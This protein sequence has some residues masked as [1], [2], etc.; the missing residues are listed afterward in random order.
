MSIVFFEL[1]YRWSVVLLNW[2]FVKTSPACLFWWKHHHPPSW[3]IQICLYSVGSCSGASWMTFSWVGKNRQHLWAWQQEDLK[4]EQREAT[5]LRP[6]WVLTV[7]VVWSLRSEEHN[8]A[9][10]VLAPSLENSFSSCIQKLFWSH[11]SDENQSVLRV[12]R[13]FTFGQVYQLKRR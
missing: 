9:W 7:C 6:V 10:Y 2:F 1:Q 4:W 11:N 12:T 5:F 8:L 3:T 13:R